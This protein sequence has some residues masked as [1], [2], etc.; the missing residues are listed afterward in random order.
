MRADDAPRGP[1]PLT[2]AHSRELRGVERRCRSSAKRTTFAGG[3]PR[4]PRCACG[5]MTL[6]AAAL[7]RD[8]RAWGE[9]ASGMPP[10]AAL[11]CPAGER[12]SGILARRAAQRRHHVRRRPAAGAAL[13]VRADDADAAAF[14]RDR[15]AGAKAQRHAA[16][17]CVFFAACAAPLARVTVPFSRERRGPSAHSTERT[18][19]AAAG[20]GSRAARAGGLR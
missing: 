13:R 3:R 8:S 10:A 17:C 18:T 12:R 7:R 11:L 15:A 16:R 1:N 19:F 6:D 9:G 2:P 4:K 14:E 5:R 20:R